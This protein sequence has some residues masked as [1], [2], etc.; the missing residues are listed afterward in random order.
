MSQPEQNEQNTQQPPQPQQPNNSQSACSH[1]LSEK[2][3]ASNERPDSE[4]VPKAARR[5]FSTS[6]KLR[7][8]READSCTTLGET[9]ALLRREG[10]YSS[11]LSDWRRMQR[12]GRLKATGTVQRGRPR[13]AVDPQALE[14]SQL[15]EDHR[16]LQLRLEQAELIIDVQKKLSQLLGLLETQNGE[17]A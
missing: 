17:P 4:V 14:L 3:A 1:S 9:G 8:L 7:I 2:K 10:L 16:R 12:E 13:E 6:Y 11:H 5:K 15:R